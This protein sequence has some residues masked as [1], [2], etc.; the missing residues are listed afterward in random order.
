[1]REDAQP[2]SGCTPRRRMRWTALRVRRARPPT[3]PA[4]T[5]RLRISVSAMHPPELIDALAANLLDA[6]GATTEERP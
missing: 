4:G 5:S 1:M 6:L 2:R 3:V